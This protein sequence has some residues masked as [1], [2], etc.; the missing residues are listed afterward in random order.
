MG[1]WDRKAR[2]KERTGSL[3]QGDDGCRITVRKGHAATNTSSTKGN[4]TRT[5][6]KAGDLWMVGKFLPTVESYKK[7]ERKLLQKGIQVCVF[8]GLPVLPVLGYIKSR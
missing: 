2:T 4:G 5:R 7:L 6:A 8:T 1:K 3:A